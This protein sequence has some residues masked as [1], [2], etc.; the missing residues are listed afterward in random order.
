MVEETFSPRSTS[1]SIAVVEAVAA[2]A[3]VSP[4]DVDP[5]LAAA[6]DPDALDRLFAP[7][8]DGRVTFPYAGHEVTVTSD[9]LVTVEAGAVR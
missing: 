1:P 8:T 6:I 9:G 2:A 4:A 3:E 5:P 7:D